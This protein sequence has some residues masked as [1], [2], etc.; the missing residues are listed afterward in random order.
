MWQMDTPKQAI[1]H[2]FLMHE[3]L[4]FSAF[5][6]AYLQPPQRRAFYALGTHHQDL[7]IRDLRRVLPNMSTD[8]A[9]AVLATSVLVTLSVFAAT[10]LDT[11]NGSP[12][13][14]SGIP[15]DD[16]L[17]IFVLIQGVS[18]V[19]ASG[20]SAVIDGPFKYMTMDSTTEL[21][22]QPQFEHLLSQIPLLETFIASQS[23]LSLA[24]RQEYHCVLSS[25]K[26]VL[27][28]AMAPASQSRELKF[29]FQWPIELSQNFL[30]LMQQKEPAALAVIGYYA[31]G[32]FAAESNYWFMEGWAE[33]TIRAVYETVDASWR[34]V[35]QWPLNHIV[36][37]EKDI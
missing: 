15:V 17:D 36:G 25:F 18:S 6:M 33:R 14:T 7:A 1:S 28:T 29:L 23:S 30:N 24:H 13:T 19:M 20:A 9:G 3:L 32:L 5:H 10:G 22:P 21:P 37:T 8:N 11:N 27:V 4:A 2:H 16:L 26:D 12:K 35:L 34:E 31:L